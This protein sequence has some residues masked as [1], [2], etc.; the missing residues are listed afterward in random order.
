MAIYYITP[1]GVNPS[2]PRKTINA[3]DIFGQVV[4]V[5][6]VTPEKDESESSVN[7]EPIPENGVLLAKGNLK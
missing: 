2:A 1:D 5:E 3:R 4:F 7:A 6:D